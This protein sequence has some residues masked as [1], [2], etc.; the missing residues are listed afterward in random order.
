[1]RLKVLVAAV[2]H[3]GL[4]RMLLVAQAVMAAQVLLLRLQAL[5]SH[6]LEAVVVVEQRQERVER[7]VAAMQAQFRGRLRLEIMELSILGVAAV[8]VVY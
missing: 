8:V 6:G 1:M 7:A 2:G 5:V 3:Q 4:V